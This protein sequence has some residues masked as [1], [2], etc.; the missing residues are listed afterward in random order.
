MDPL[1]PKQNIIQ[2]LAAVCVAVCNGVAAARCAALRTASESMQM[3]SSEKVCRSSI[4]VTVRSTC[5]VH[6]HQQRRN[7]N[8]DMP[9]YVRNAFVRSPGQ[10]FYLMLSVRGF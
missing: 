2:D 4:A 5:N 9:D 7:Q 1:W 3:K 6:Q 8:P 10:F